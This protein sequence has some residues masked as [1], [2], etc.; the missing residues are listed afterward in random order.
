MEFKEA[1]IELDI[2]FEDLDAGGVIHHPNYIKVCERARGR[3]LA[4]NNI[5]FKSLKDKDV[6]L[7]VRSIQADYLK[8]ISMERVKVALKILSHSEKSIVI[9]HEISPVASQ[10][11]GAY[12]TADIA[13]VTA[14]YS[15]AKSCPL[16]NEILD[17]IRIQGI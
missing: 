13:F 16:P 14:N 5:T 2:E 6:A 10:R 3:W 4:S 11:P 9:R 7:A 17:F 12:F 1:V 15:T 8:P